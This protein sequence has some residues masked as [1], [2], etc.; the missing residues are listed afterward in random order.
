MRCSLRD[1]LLEFITEAERGEE[2]DFSLS[3]EDAVDL[4]ANHRRAD[5]H[6]RIDCRAFGEATEA[7]SN[8]GKPPIEAAWITRERQLAKRIRDDIYGRHERIR[9]FDRV[10]RA[11][12]AK[13]SVG[14]LVARGLR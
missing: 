6:D 8:P 7:E 14:V 11:D 4:I 9:T 13:I 3:R 2:E 1:E 10:V 5:R 12:G